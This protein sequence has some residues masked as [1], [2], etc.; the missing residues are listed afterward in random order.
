ML[1]WV[2]GGGGLLGGAVSRQSASTFAGST[3]P[4][5]SP[6][7]AISVLETDLRRFASLVGGSGWSVV[8]AAGSG[9]V[10][11][12][13]PELRSETRVMEGFAAAL[14]D[15]R[16][17]GEGSFF[18]ASSAGGVYAGSSR[19]PFSEA[20]SPH[21]LSSYGH[22]KLEQE[23]LADQLLGG[24]IPV[25]IGRLSNLYGPGQNVAKPQGLVSQLCLAAVTRRALN[26][27]VPMDTARDYLYVDDAARM[28][29]ELVAGAGR[30]QPERTELRILASGRPISVGSVLRTVQLVAH[31]PIRIAAGRAP[32]SEAHAHDLRLRSDFSDHIARMAT[33]PLP[34]GVKRVYDHTL[35]VLRDHP[36]LGTV[37]A[38]ATPETGAL[39]S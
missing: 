23:G 20:T 26:L 29:V 1:T 10:A 13:P 24:A 18:L 33:T 7:A 36:H 34:V 39:A 3:V 5:T 4:W 11:S 9:V 37:V 17:S 12:S 19:P 21:P 15:L 6:G 16:P 32:S 35:R 38:G 8:W 22:A 30:R 2:I 14:K 31:R 27:F 25:I 28:I